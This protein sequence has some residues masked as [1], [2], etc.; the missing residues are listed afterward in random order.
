MIKKGI[1]M[2]IQNHKA[3][4]MN[5]Q[6]TFDEITATS[7]MRVGEEI[8]YGDQST[9]K[10]LATLCM[11]FVMVGS[12]FGFNLMSENKAPVSYVA[13][14]INPGVEFT[15]NIYNRIIS[16][17]ATNKDGELLL[18]GLDYKGQDIDDA[19]NDFINEA[20]KLGYIDEN[21]DD[22]A[23]LITVVNDNEVTAVSLQDTLYAS[24]N[25]YFS[26]NHILGVVL[27]EETNEV[28]RLEAQ[29][30]G[31]SAGKLRLVKQAVKA[32]P[33]LSQADA[34]SMP[35]KE[36]NKVIEAQST[37]V[38]TSVEEGLI[39]EKE[40]TIMSVSKF[41]MRSDIAP[42]MASADDAAFKEKLDEFQ[43]EAKDKDLSA[44]WD[45]INKELNDS[46]ENPTTTDPKATE[47]QPK[48]EAEVVPPVEKKIIVEKIKVQPKE[49]TPKIAN[50][51]I[52]EK[53]IKENSEN[54]ES[55]P[56]KAD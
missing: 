38:E 32:D 43:N 14:D 7:S 11:L 9:T 37:P 46:K 30:E 13:V 5:N 48:G 3:V 41:R 23:V 24:V 45:E 56:K 17:S 15:L 47:S 1:I 49:I 4:I 28:L 54:S 55:T 35:V 40:Q 44:K 53:E 39:E 42:M 31:L 29:K 50:P 22:N 25:Q 8:K 16:A 21:K 34:V 26:D 12:I 20:Y 18:A 36:L 10:V 6:G 2:D 33:N 51:V 19:V 27:G 52:I